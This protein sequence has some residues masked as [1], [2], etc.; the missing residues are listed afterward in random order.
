MTQ[1]EARVAERYGELV[2]LPRTT[3]AAR[4]A[5][6]WPGSPSN[7]G[8]WDW[9]IDIGEVYY[10]PG[11][12]KMLGIRPTPFPAVS[13]PWLRLLHPTELERVRPGGAHAHPYAGAL[14]NRISHADAGRGYRW[15]L[16]R[17]RVAERD[18][19]RT[20]AHRGHPYRHHRPQGSTNWPSG[21]ASPY[22]DL[23]AT[24][25]MRVEERTAQLAAA[26]AAKSQF[27]GAHEP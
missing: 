23:N 26:S 15:I 18:H 27:H 10:S 8:L 7:D 14:R 24:L 19:R 12:F 2:V 13:T 22:R 20:L 3:G 6:G 21:T 1:L 17:G 25:E 5:S 16:S 4:C 11:Y 9:R